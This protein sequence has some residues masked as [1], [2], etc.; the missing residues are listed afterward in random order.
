MTTATEDRVAFLAER[1]TGIGG[2]DASA[3]CGV[4]PWRTSLDVF[5]EKLG[6]EVP[7]EENDAMYWGNALE[8]L[9]CEE[10]SKRTG[11][12]VRRARALKRSKAHPHMIAH[13]DRSCDPK[14][15]ERKTIVEAKTAGRWAK[16]DDFGEEG[17]DE[18]PPYYLTQCHHNMIVT[19]AEVC[20]LPIL[21]AGQDFRI[22]TVYASKKVSEPLI[23][24][25]REF[26]QCVQDMEA[27]TDVTEA[28]TRKRYPY[29]HAATLDATEDAETILILGRLLD[30]QLRIDSLEEVESE[31]RGWLRERIGPDFEAIKL[32]SKKVAHCKT[33][34]AH[35]F[36]EGAFAAK[37]PDLF[38]IFKTPRTSRPLTLNKKALAAWLEKNTTKEADV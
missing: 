5:R 8:D 7:I 17:T 12:K 13:L 18:L 20:D 27:P 11:R 3:V 34:T 16:L 24:I 32:G 30:A 19:G 1:Q 22:Y 2:S 36:D 21:I 4:N 6:L 31:C 37:F 15:G 38:S 25:E 10:Y 33:Q 9:V 28:A 26:W 29:S 35:R 23:E 14:P